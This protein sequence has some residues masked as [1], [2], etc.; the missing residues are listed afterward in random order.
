MELSSTRTTSSVTGGSTLTALKPRVSTASMINTLLREMLLLVL[1]VMPRLTTLLL[2]PRLLMLVTLLLPSTLVLKVLVSELDVR[3]LQDVEEED[4]DSK[5]LGH[6]H[7]HSG[8][9]IVSQDFVFLV[10]ATSYFSAIIS[11]VSFLMSVSYFLVVNIIYAI[12]QYNS[13]DTKI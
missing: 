9:T 5:H 8:Q 2:L 4:R 11:L 10:N 1:L 3:D 12:Y 13:R 7:H 6:H